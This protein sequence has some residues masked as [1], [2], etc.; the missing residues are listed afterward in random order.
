MTSIVMDASAVLAL[1]R[2]E[3]GA[4]KVGP[5]VGR[6]RFRRSTSRKSLRSFYSAAWM[7]P[8]SARFSTS[9]VWI[10][11]LTT[12]TPPM[13]RPDCTHRQESSDVAS[14]LV[15]VWRSRSSW[16]FPPSLL[17]ANGRR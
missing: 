12:W 8:P 16:A 11:E 17:I 4:D 13:R 6:A 9:F 7:P 5:H 15:P 14:V 3:P 2:D 10:S 1:V